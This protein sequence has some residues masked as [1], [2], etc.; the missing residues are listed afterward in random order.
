[1]FRNSLHVQQKL[2]KFAIPCK[3]RFE[4]SRESNLDTI[5]KCE[6]VES[7]GRGGRRY[8]KNYKTLTIN[9]KVLIN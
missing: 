8:H 2:S 5:S 3:F 1:M 4:I 6:R 7:L 9:D